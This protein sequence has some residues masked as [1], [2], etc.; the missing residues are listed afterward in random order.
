[1]PASKFLTR[2]P[3]P[4]YYAREIQR[5]R[6]YFKRNPDK[7]LRIV[8]AGWFDEFKTANE[9]DRWVINALNRRINERGGLPDCRGRK[10][11]LDYQSAL[12]RDARRIADCI[13]HQVI[14]RQ[15][16]TAEA[17]ERFDHLLTRPGDE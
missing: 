4:G 9:F 16:E 8:H 13:N 10:D 12:Q 2:L 11:T 6:D 7:G 15:F 14:V 17:R 3:K 5:G 1:M